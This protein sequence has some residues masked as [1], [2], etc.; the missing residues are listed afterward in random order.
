[1]RTWYQKWIK[2]CADGKRIAQGEPLAW[3]V[4]IEGEQDTFFV[5]SLCVH[6]ML[7]GSNRKIET[8]PL[9]SGDEMA[10]W[11]SFFGNLLLNGE[12]VLHLFCAQNGHATPALPAIHCAFYPKSWMYLAVSKIR[13]RNGD[14]R[15]W[16]CYLNYSDDE[17]PL[18]DCLV[19]GEATADNHIF[20]T[21]P[22]FNQRKMIAWIRHFGD[23]LLYENNRMLIE[24]QK[25]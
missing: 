22:I 24:L 13:L 19:I 7:E 8:N 5:K 16:R 10:A 15:H 4:W 17:I 18:A 25:P 14:P 23:V 11:V 9:A 6:G 21:N 12:N 1:M 2:I 20:E 3:R